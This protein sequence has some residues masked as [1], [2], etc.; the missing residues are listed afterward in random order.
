M[1]AGREAMAAEENA[2]KHTCAAPIKLSS[3]TNA[4]CLN[5]CKQKYGDEGKG[6]CLPGGCLCSFPC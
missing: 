4:I 3:C 1:D 6:V 5:L 2:V